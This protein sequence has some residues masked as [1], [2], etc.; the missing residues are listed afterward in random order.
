MHN[1][2]LVVLVPAVREMMVLP[3]FLFSNREGALML[4]NSLRA[5][6]SV[7]QIKAQISKRIIAS[8]EAENLRLLLAAFLALC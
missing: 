7:L 4:Y 1:Q 3:A 5:K 8:H 2:S 6:G